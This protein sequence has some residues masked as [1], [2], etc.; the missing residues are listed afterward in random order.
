[1]T[2]KDISRHPV[3]L[4][5]GASAVVEPAFTGDLAWYDAYIQRH[6]DDGAE[7]RLV[8]MYTFTEDWEMWEVHPEGSEVVLCVAG[9]MTLH[10][11][12]PDGSRASVTL[13]AGQYAINEPGTW[14]TADVETE[15]TAVFITAGKGTQHRPRK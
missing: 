4:G 5:L 13:N 6:S 12:N 7:G 2:A 11:E 8:G 3:H 10:Q 1:M 9:E 15:A 14:H